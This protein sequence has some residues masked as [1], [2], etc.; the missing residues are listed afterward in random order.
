MGARYQYQQTMKNGITYV[1]E[2]E[3]EYVPEKKQTRKKNRKLI[4]K[5]DENGNIVP[6]RK[7]GMKKETEANSE[8]DNAAIKRLERQIASANE[9]IARLQDEISILKAS[10]AALRKAMDKAVRALTEGLEG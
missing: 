2:C 8:A 1:F 10:N 7:K 6:T 4:G 3:D 9:N 5:L